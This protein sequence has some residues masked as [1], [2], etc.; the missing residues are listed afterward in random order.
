MFHKLNQRQQIPV[1]LLREMPILVAKQYEL[2]R[3][4]FSQHYM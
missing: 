4:Y 2:L 1:I 3:M